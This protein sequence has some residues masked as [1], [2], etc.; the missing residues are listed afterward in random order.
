MPETPNTICEYTPGRWSS[1]GPLDGGGPGGGGPPD[2]GLMGRGPP[3]G[4]KGG[5]GRPDGDPADAR[6]LPGEW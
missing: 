2:G 3:G 1:R 6:S 4:G 5:C